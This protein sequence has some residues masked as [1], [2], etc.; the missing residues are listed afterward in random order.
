VLKRNQ[1]YPVEFLP[2]IFKENSWQKPQPILP[3]LDD[4][5]YNTLSSSLLASSL[6]ELFIDTKG[7]KGTVYRTPL[8][9]LH[10]TVQQ[11]KKNQRGIRGH[12]KKLDFEH[13]R[14]HMSEWD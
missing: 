14:F 2:W 7:M 8:E 3:H 6:T 4:D 12:R 10:M 1:E 9:S 11:N 5:L 13:D